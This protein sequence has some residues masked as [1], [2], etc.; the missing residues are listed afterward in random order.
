M[1]L[2]DVFA[3][4]PH[5]EF[6]VK[7]ASRGHPPHSPTTPSPNTTTKKKKKMK[8]QSSHANIRKYHTREAPEISNNLAESENQ[9]TKIYIKVLTK[10][11]KNQQWKR[12]KTKWPSGVE[13]SVDVLSLIP[14]TFCHFISHCICIIDWS[15]FPRIGCVNMRLHC[16]HIY[17]K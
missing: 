12:P 16:I 1:N 4:A 9:A 11:K 8:E 6:L 3:S 7:S 17:T 2:Q 13:I 10:Q 15:N 14:K 5:P